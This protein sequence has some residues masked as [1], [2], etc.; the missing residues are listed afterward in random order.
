MTSVKFTN[1]SN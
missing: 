1:N